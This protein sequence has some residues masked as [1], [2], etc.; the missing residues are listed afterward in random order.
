M[1]RM[2]AT[3]L[4]LS[5][6][7]MS[8][9]I[10][11]SQHSGD[12]ECAIWLGVSYFWSSADSCPYV[13]MLLFGIDTDPHPEVQVQPGIGTGFAPFGGQYTVSW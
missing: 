5:I 1:T 8:T 9:A 11:Q 3:L 7:L 10:A 2:H 12:T 6:A 4:T 13:S